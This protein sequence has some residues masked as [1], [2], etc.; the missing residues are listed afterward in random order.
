[1]S[2]KFTKTE[3][4]GL[5][6]MALLQGIATQLGSWA[7]EECD[8]GVPPEQMDELYGIMTR[9]ANRVAKLFGYEEAWVNT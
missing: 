4:K 3:L 5:A 1:M 8:K 2:K 7:P 9:E 6:Q